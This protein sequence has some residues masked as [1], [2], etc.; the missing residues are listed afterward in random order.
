MMNR[1]DQ[2]PF[3][4]RTTEESI[5]QRDDHLCFAHPQPKSGEYS[6]PAL[7]EWTLSAFLVVILSAAPLAVALLLG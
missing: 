3:R 7:I 1:M 6:A 2:T 5:M 4:K